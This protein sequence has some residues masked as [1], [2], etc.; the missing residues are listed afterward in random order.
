[1]HYLNLLRLFLLQCTLT[2]LVHTANVR[3]EGERPLE[4]PPH[5]IYNPVKARPEPKDT[6]IENVP[7]ALAIG[8]EP[9]LNH[10]DPDIDLGEIIKHLL[11]LLNKIKDALDDNTTTSTIRAAAGNTP[12]ATITSTISLVQNPALKPKGAAYGCGN[13]GG[14]YS[15]CSSSITNFAA[16]PAETQAGCLCNV[17]SRRRLER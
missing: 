8:K 4:I 7:G 17:F 11:E 10:Q 12:T 1:M 3:P 6:P 14:I 5:Q 9:Y 15:S 13:A 16:L 2:T